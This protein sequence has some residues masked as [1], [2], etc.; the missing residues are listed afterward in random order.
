MRQIGVILCIAIF[1]FETAYAFDGFLSDKNTRLVEKER[2][3]IFDAENKSE[4]FVFAEDIDGETAKD[5]SNDNISSDDWG[6]YAPP[7]GEDGNPQKITPLGS[8][9]VTVFL[10]L[11]FLSAVYFYRK[12]LIKPANKLFALRN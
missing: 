3:S 7:P 5:Q 6:L 4:K 12:K 11:S 9:D 10:I 8:S 1:S 2:K